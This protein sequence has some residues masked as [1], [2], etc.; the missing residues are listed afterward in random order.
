M[1]LWLGP[2]IVRARLA[3]ET[4]PQELE[5]IESIERLV[6]T[7]MA[8]Y[9]NE[10]AIPAER[11]A[12]LMFDVVRFARS[13]LWLSELDLH[14]KRILELGGPSLST[15]VVG[16]FFPD[17]TWV[18]THFDL[19]TRFP[20]KDA[21]FDVILNMEVIE[22][23]FDLEPL[24]AV[25]LSGVKHVLSECHRVLAEGGSMFLTTPNATSFWIIQRA[26]LAES[27]MLYDRH[28][29]EFTVSE[30]KSLLE[31]A[32]F[33]IDRATT[34]KVWHFWDFRTIE[35]F[36]LENG[37]PAENRGDDVFVLARKV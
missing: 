10:N 31:E 22:H 27:P 16:R 14:S 3:K 23:I 11:Q 9:L 25:T 7:E 12:A 30:V 33:A 15:R 19:R 35:N 24:H 37:Y 17:N 36:L 6:R 34:E 28:F 13:I 18:N 1:K 26:M 5:N 20:Y 29:H 8:S 2:L 32:G 4:T 21:S